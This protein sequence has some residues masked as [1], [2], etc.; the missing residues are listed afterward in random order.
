MERDG[1]A[2]GASVQPAIA[3]M[4]GNYMLQVPNITTTETI[5]SS[6]IS[7]AQA[8]IEYAAPITPKALSDY[9]TVTLY[10][11]IDTTG[12][13]SARRHQ[14]V[15]TAGTPVVEFTRRPPIPWNCW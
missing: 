12:A 2:P 7:I 9:P 15:R 10:Q 5:S 4:W 8:N 3:G 6:P 14:G 1:A 11:L 13:P